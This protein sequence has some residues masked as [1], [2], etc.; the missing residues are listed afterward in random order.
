[1]HTKDKDSI[2]VCFPYSFLAFSLFEI[3]CSRDCPFYLTESVKVP[4]SVKAPVS[5]SS[6]Q[7]QLILTLVMISTL[8]F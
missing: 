3:P 8:P 2:S 4:E 5:V 7:G 1:M 6:G